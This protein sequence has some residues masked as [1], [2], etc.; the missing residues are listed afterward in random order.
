M[1]EWISKGETKTEK[2]NKERKK[3]RGR[4]IPR[5]LSNEFSN[6]EK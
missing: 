4:R 5:S 1:V 6:Y 2:E 3:D